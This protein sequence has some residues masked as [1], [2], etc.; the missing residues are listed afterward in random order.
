MFILSWLFF[1]FNLLF[2]VVSFVPCIMGGAMG[3]DSPQAQKDPFAILLSILFLTFPVVCLFCGILSPVFQY[4]K[5]SPLCV[6]VGVWP[7]IEAAIVILIL[8]CIGN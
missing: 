6:L 1:I 4:F 2:A 8:F 3:M 5:L 7:S